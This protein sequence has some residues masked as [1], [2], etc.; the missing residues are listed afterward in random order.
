MTT[1]EKLTSIVNDDKVI[2]C[3][4]N[5]YDRW[6]DEHEYEDINEYGKVIFGVIDRNHPKYGISLI[7]TTKRPFGIKVKMDDKNIHIHIKNKGEY[8]VIVAKSF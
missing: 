8:S 2:E 6:L 1:I 4:F 3:F 5:L 7:A